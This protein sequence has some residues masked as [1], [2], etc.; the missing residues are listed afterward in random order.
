VIVPSYT[1]AT[2]RSPNRLE[3]GA[4]RILME[5]GGAA[6]FARFILRA[7]SMVTPTILLDAT[8]K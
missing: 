5:E 1:F 3:Y 2:E 8:K 4:W 7:L 6:I